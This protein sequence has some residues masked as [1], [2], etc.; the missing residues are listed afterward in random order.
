MAA[1]S[2]NEDERDSQFIDAFAVLRVLRIRKWLIATLVVLGTGLGF[3]FGLHQTP[4]FTASAEILVENPDSELSNVRE[5]E[6]RVLDGAALETEVKLLTSRAHVERIIQNVSALDALDGWGD[7]TGAGGG[8]EGAFDA[9]GNPW[10]IIGQAFAWFGAGDDQAPAAK[11]DVDLLSL[12]ERVKLFYDN[13]NVQQSGDSRIISV[14]Y[15]SSDPE[16]AANVANESADLYISRR[17]D[18]REFH[19]SEQSGWL[20]ERAEGLRATLNSIENEIE[21]F[22]AEYNL[23]TTRYDVQSEELLGFSTELIKLRS[24]ISTREARLAALT[25]LRSKRQPVFNLPEISGNETIS[26]LK[27]QE[28]DLLRREA[29]LGN[30]FGPRHPEML[31]LQVEKEKVAQRI[32]LEVERIIGSLKADIQILQE[33]KVALDTEVKNIRSQHASQSEIQVQLREREREAEATR[34]LYQRFLERSKEVEEVSTNSRPGASVISRASPPAISDTPAPAMLG[35]MGFCL[36]FLGGTMIAVLLEH[37][38]QRIRSDRQISSQ[39]GLR[40]LA[41][42]PQVKRPG[43]K[44]RLH[45]YL[46]DKPMSAYTDAIRNTLLDLRAEME[47]EDAKVVVAASTLPNEGK[48]TVALS[49]A[50][51]AAQSGLRTLVVDLDL[52]HPSICEELGQKHRVG[53]VDHAR[54]NASFEDIVWTHPTIRNLEVVMTTEP[55][56]DSI[57]I[58]SSEPLEMFLERAR[59]IYDLIII[60]GPPIFAV[61]DARVVASLGEMV[62][63]VIRWGE[64]DR[65]TAKAGL[66]RLKDDGIEV[67]GAVLSQVN[68][69]KHRAYEFRDAS[70][71][72]KEYKGY[73]VN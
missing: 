14:S 32:N 58:L 20:N 19:F 44:K 40:S 70:H 12:E 42:I 18:S 4:Q 59:R 16:E 7:D 73:Y 56:A 48:T 46:L 17:K 49:L 31:A 47:N 8:D 61:S 34:Q 51:L 21:K 39:L 60:D 38:D 33:Q 66:Q 55:C 36:S 53:I 1:A 37:K 67:T 71:H 3:F 10:S 41:M 24:E 5:G 9:T 23:Q 68:F 43:G 27:E 30:V 54:G 11:I 35:I 52:R 45:E 62:L 29:E 69:S 22:R 28:S 25:D 26:G 63:F 65:D 13:Y 57:Q 64:T 15:T 72:Y 6:R 50:V 2:A